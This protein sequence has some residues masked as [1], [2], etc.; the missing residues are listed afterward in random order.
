MIKIFCDMDGV[1]VDLLGSIKKHLGNPKL[2]QGLIDDFFYSE[3]GTGT[4]CVVE[5]DEAELL[6]HPQHDVFPK[7]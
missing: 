7:P 3:A 6:R 1:L 2:N 5:F 4:E